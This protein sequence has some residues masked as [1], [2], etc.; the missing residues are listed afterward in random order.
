MVLQLVFFLVPARS[1]LCGLPQNRAISSTF[2]EF[3]GKSSKKMLVVEV[4]RALRGTR[5]KAFQGAG[6]HPYFRGQENNLM[7]LQ[8]VFFLVP[9]ESPLCGLPLPS[10]RRAYGRPSEYLVKTR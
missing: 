5:K 9:A 7:V 8:L 1:P 4:R 6:Q 10:Y 2:S 3:A